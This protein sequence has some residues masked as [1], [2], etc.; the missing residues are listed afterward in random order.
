MR[1]TNDVSEMWIPFREAFHDAVEISHQ[2]VV[3]QHPS[4]RN[5]ISHDLGSV[6]LWSAMDTLYSAKKVSIHVVDDQSIINQSEGRLI[7]TIIVQRENDLAL[8]VIRNG[9]SFLT[10]EGRKHAPSEYKDAEVFAEENGKGLYA[11]PKH[12]LGFTDDPINARGEIEMCKFTQCPKANH[13]TKCRFAD[14]MPWKLRDLGL[15]FIRKELIVCEKDQLLHVTRSKANIHQSMVFVAESTIPNAGCGLFLRP[16]STEMYFNAGDTLCLY[17]R[18]TLTEEQVGGLSNQDYVLDVGESRFADASVF[19]GWNLGWFVN[20]G[21]LLEGL[22]KLATDFDKK[23]F[24]PDSAEKVVERFC[25]VKFSRNPRN[26]VSIKVKDRLRCSTH[27]TAKELFVNYGL[28]DYWIKYI[29]N[30]D[31]A[32]MEHDSGD[33]LS[34]LVRWIVA[35]NRRSGDQLKLIHSYS[36]AQLDWLVSACPSDCPVQYT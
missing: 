26:K 16:H 18:E 14:C 20:Q 5:P 22:K 36:D 32:T 4:S 2:F 19:H 11:I 33:E 34:Q 13:A 29:S 24:R 6:A 27:N 21:G 25:N 17:S 12:L 8:Q 28:L 23:Y 30:I 3:S 31:S 35:T 9:V 7:V 15:D 10:E 1:F